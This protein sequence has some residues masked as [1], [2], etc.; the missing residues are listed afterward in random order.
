[1]ETSVMSEQ[2]AFLASILANPDDDTPRLVFA[3][4]LDEHGE[5]WWAGLIR[6]QCHSAGLQFTER[7]FLRSA[8]RWFR[9]HGGPTT[10]GDGAVSVSHERRTATKRRFR[11]GEARPYLT[12]FVLRRG[13]VGEARYETLAGF[14]A[15]APKLFA[16]HPIT[17][18]RIDNREPD[19]DATWHVR[20]DWQTVRS[21]LPADFFSGFWRYGILPEGCDALWGNVEEAAKAFAELCVAHGREQAGLT[22][23]PGTPVDN[24]AI[25]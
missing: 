4:W 19:S 16:A 11:Y 22:P 9:Q 12:S 6:W 23:R 2:G 20:P 21:G 15:E 1:M 14:L 25:S 3:D 7:E 24:T 5:E 17:A 8:Q 18:V 13:F 10:R